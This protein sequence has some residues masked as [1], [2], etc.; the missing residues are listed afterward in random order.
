MVE[1]VLAS[2]RASRRRQTRRILVL[3]GLPVAGRGNGKAVKER[4]LAAVLKIAA[5]LLFAL[6]Y[7]AQSA[8]RHNIPYVDIKRSKTERECDELS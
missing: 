2:Q 1:A 4:G 3:K 6:L 7:Y 5:I 8:S